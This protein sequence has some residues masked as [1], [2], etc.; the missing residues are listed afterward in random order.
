MQLIDW[1]TRRF[2]RHGPHRDQ[3][4]RDLLCLFHPST[5]VI[6]RLSA[7]SRRNS[8]HINEVISKV[9]EEARATNTPIVW[10]RESDFKQLFEG[11]GNTTKQQIATSMA[12]C[13]P[14]IEWKLPPP[15]KPWQTED[16]RMV[17]FDAVALG[18]AYFAIT[19]DPD[20]AREMFFVANPFQRL[21][22]GA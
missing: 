14:E 13:F 21:P 18:F 8:P 9:R 22:R 20:A 16:W 3:I 12:G 10:V 19:M 17:L 11:L 5:L 1:G 6:R 2:C 15:R 4:L 7:R